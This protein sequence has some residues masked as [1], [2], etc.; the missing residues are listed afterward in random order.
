[1]FVEPSTNSMQYDI[2]PYLLDPYYGLTGWILLFSSFF[3]VMF[4]REVRNDRTVASAL[5]IILVFHHLVAIANAYITM[6]PGT[7][8]SFSFVTR[9]TQLAEVGKITVAMPYEKF[10][11][12]VFVIFASSYFMVEELSVLTFAFSCVVFIKLIN[13]TNVRR[14]RVGLLML[15]GLLPSITLYTSVGSREAYQI[16]SL[17]LTVYFGLR[18]HVKPMIGARLLMILS[19]LTLGL[20]HHALIIVTVALVPLL[21]LWKI[22]KSS[23]KKLFVFS[24]RRCVNGML[25]IIFIV[26]GYYYTS[27][28]ALFKNYGL[29]PNRPISDYKMHIEGR[30][31]ALK[32]VPG[33]TNYN[34]QV[35]LSSITSAVGTTL[36]SLVYYLFSPFPWQ[37]R[38]P[39]DI[40]PGF[41]ALIRFLLIVFSI[42]SWYESQGPQRRLYG[43][44]LFACFFVTIFFAYG[45][46]NYGT[47]MRHNIV[48]HWLLVLVGGSGLI[49]FV[50]K[51]ILPISKSE[52]HN[53]SCEIKEY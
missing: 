45:T 3:V 19:A 29:N 49:R 8:D 44:L 30:G 38:V 1:M 31:R 34:S 32:F 5:L 24:K 4:F 6:L 50:P 37:I 26:G 14:H 47:A 13:L 22:H 11:S 33:R 36:H 41:E 46:G 40:I 51:Y 23:I 48:S 28:N 39:V 21:L 2:N 35:D 7:I 25:V 9:A 15:Y 16:L 20:L 42:K 27:S 43:L 53:T 10:L 18:I 17:M 52:V 12:V